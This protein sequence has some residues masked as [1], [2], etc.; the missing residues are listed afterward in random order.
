LAEATTPETPAPDLSLLKQLQAL[1]GE[2]P[3]LV[4][5]RVELLSLEL[6]RAAQSLVQVVALT[7][8]IAILGVTVWL[9]LWAALIGLLMMAAGLPLLAALALTIGINLVA[10]AV[11]VARVRRLLPRLQLPATRRHLT[12]PPDPRPSPE[13]RPDDPCTAAH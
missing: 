1:A 2:L 13:I 3:R 8:A 5:D 4:S 9:A 10:I 11:A 6:Q 12:V 7:V